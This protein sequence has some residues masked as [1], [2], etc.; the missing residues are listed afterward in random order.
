[1][2]ILFQ[3]YIVLKFPDNSKYRSPSSY[4]ILEHLINII[5]PRSFP[6]YEYGLNRNTITWIF[7]STPVWHL[8]SRQPVNKS[9]MDF[10]M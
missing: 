10:E 1:M 7:K 3:D 4:K 6:V 9:V 5:S 2:L 8:S